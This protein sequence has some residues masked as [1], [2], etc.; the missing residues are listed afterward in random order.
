MPGF[1]ANS[2]QPDAQAGEGEPNG[3]PD[4]MRFL[5]VCSLIC[6][7]QECTVSVSSKEEDELFVKQYSTY[8]SHAP[9]DI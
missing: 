2:I 6:N 7:F 1:R 4:V 8:I 9:S 5:T 3:S